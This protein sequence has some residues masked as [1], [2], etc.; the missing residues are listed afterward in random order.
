MAFDPTSA[1]SDVCPS[2]SPAL[3]CLMAFA[4]PKPTL[5]PTFLSSY[6]RDHSFHIT[7]KNTLG[8][9]R[10]LQF[11]RESVIHTRDPK[12]ESRSPANRSLTSIIDE[13]PQHSSIPQSPLAPIPVAGMASAIPDPTSE[14]PPP[15]EPQ[16][17]SLPPELWIRILSYH[18]DLLHLWTTCRLVSPIFSAYVEQAFAETH[19]R[20]AR[21]DFML[22]KHNL[23]GRT[24][25]PEVPCTFA[26]LG[27]IGAD[28]S[29]DG[30]G[31]GVG[32]EGGCVGGGNG[33]ETVWFTDTRP[34]SA[35]CAQDVAGFHFQTAHARSRARSKAKVSRKA[36]DVEAST[37][38][39]ILERWE[40]RVRNSK[41][42]TPHYVI[43]L[44]GLVNDT[45]LPELKIDVKRR[46]ISFRWRE[47]LTLFFREQAWLVQLAAQWEHDVEAQILE[48]R[49]TVLE[50]GK[51]PPRKF[52]PR[53]SAMI[54]I[55]KQIRRR[56]LREAYQGNEKMQWAVESLKYFEQCSAYAQGK[57][58]LVTSIRIPGASVGEKWFGSVPLLQ[59]LYLDEW[60]CMHRIDVKEEHLGLH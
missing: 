37:F 27:D 58:K 51:P 19:L 18:T 33:R 35:V 5:D 30:G 21:I 22:E 7:E 28:H 8:L 20:T 44:G 29:G 60:S 10:P 34:R 38:N 52:L 17:P 6:F 42:E 4:R 13:H 56:R 16:C 23:G 11:L 41:P 36:E 15:P 55:R 50:G 43:S 57:L 59:G 40:D 12:L 32:S 39:F 49:K 53:V 1:F 26:S 3:A 24:H 2:V 25:R 47:M 14:L 54:E 9:Y 48:D 45:A 46:G 31:E